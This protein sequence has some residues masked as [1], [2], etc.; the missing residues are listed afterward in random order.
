M[1]FRSPT[2]QNAVTYFNVLGACTLQSVKVYSDS[3]GMRQI[4]LRNSAGAV[5][6]TYNVNITADT[7]LIPLN[8]SLTPGTGYQITTD[9]ATNTARFGGGVVAPYFWRSSTGAVYPYTNS[10]LVSV[11]GNNAGASG[12]NRLYYFY[13]WVVS[14]PAEV[15]TSSRTVVTATIGTVGI[16]AINENTEVQVYPNPAS[17]EATILF[18]NNIGNTATV[19]LTDV[20]GRMVNSWMYDK[21]STGQQLKLNLSGLNAGTYFVSIKSNDKTFVQKLILTK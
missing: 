19:V 15:C 18:D 3:M 9:S 2:N 14:G 6:N 17:D 16:S 10:P 5:L 12:T 4:K 8:W 20:A 21:T 1:L 7:T 13:D 11:S